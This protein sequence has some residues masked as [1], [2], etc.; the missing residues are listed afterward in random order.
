M[1]RTKPLRI[2]NAGGYWGDDPGAMRRQVEGAR[3]DYITLDFLAEI[4]M[5][6][7]QKQRAKD[8]N[9]GYARDFVPM[10]LDV[11]P[12][13]LERKIRVI[14]N[15]GGIN[16]VACAKAILAGA[17]RMG[18]SP[19][20]A[21]V[22]GDCL[23]Q[24]LPHL[25]AQGVELSNMETGEKFI[26]VA[27]KV[28]AANVY[29]GAAPVV[30]AL[31]RWQPDIIVTGRVTDTGIT[32]APM[33]YE[34]GWAEDDWDKLAAGIVAGHM[35]ECGSQVT[36]G[37]FSDW[38][39]IECFDKIGYPVVEMQ[40]SGT[41]HIS[42]TDHSGGLVS[43]DTVRE[44]LFY[45]MG[46]PKVYISPDVIVDFSTVTLKEVA[47]NTVEVAG[48]SGLAPTDSYKVSMAFEDRYKAVGSILVCGPEARAKAEKFAEIFWQKIGDLNFAETATEYLGWN[49]CHR[50][51]SI[52]PDSTEIVLRLGAR[53]EKE[54][55]L[56]AFGRAISSLILSGPPGVTVLGGVPRVAQIMH[57]WP[58][59]LPKNLVK[60]MIGVVEA[61]GGMSGDWL[62]VE[63]VPGESFTAGASHDQTAD[64]ADMAVLD[65]IGMM[66]KGD[67]LLSEL[68]LARSGDK[69][70]SVNIGVLAR[71]AAA[72]KLVREYL[73]A[74][75]I[76]NLFQELCFG[77]VR[78][79][80]VDGLHGLNFILEESLGGGGS[81]TL[82]ADAQGKTFSQAL[83]R[84]RL[85]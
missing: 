71:D 83:L 3:P 22:S 79:Y 37:N 19:T 40:A 34:F 4:T 58:A 43:L 17:E 55:D 39:K 50:S 42:K 21:V 46:D 31:R 36:G 65:A 1:T 29:F 48:A 85:P 77:Q 59:L 11:L 13:L 26:E 53:S 14:S 45:E 84:L 61:I 32:L 7:L 81:C 78:R 51:L 67:T 2:A 52:E 64:Q 72:Y 47:V 82:R 30:E 8:E 41:F 6:I 15:A 44:Q 69:G 66:Q 5:S 75:R 12:E 35:I 73:T 80:S 23:L 49:A 28:R 25:V 57:Y 76:K 70:D 18:L 33:M 20:I 62:E 27:D 74:Q 68:C 56:Q 10:V 38:R 54:K 60:P 63:C 16:P 24:R 9:L